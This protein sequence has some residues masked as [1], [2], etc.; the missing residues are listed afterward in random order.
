M[1]YL[2]AENA[3]QLL[4]ITRATGRF[5]IRMHLH[6]NRRAHISLHILVA[7]GN[8]CVTVCEI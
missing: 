2:L 4:V 8:V 3:L 6:A 7:S 5:G 1:Y